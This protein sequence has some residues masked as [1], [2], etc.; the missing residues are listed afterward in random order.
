MRLEGTDA[1]GRRRPVPVPGETFRIPADTLIAA[2]SQE[3]DW[4][5]LDGIRPGGAWIE[6]EAH[7]EFQP[8]VWAGGDLRGLGIAGMA[9]AHGRAAAEAVHRRLRGN[10]E[11]LPSDAR[12]RVGPGDVKPQYYLDRAPVAP[13]IVPVEDRLSDPER[14]GRDTI[15]EEQFLA[16]VARCFSC[17]LCFGCR[18]CH[19]YCNARAFAGVA[20]LAPG[21]YFALAIDLCDRCG[22][23]VDLCPCGYLSPSSEAR[24]PI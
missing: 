2:V 9:I 15:D 5:L 7:H 10:G 17:G 6:G 19:T 1:S 18:H 22:K 16:E 21:A 3:P 24:R 8:G 23:C 14:E 12:T 4:T 11:D 20:S 13:P